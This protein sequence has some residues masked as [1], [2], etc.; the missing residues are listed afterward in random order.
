MP[1]PEHLISNGDGHSLDNLLRRTSA[2]VLASHVAELAVKRTSLNGRQANSVAVAHRDI[3]DASPLTVKRLEV[4]RQRHSL[5][6]NLVT[7][8]ANDIRIGTGIKCQRGFRI[9]A[10]PLIEW[11]V[12]VDVAWQ[13]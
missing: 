5:G 10:E 3:G 9:R 4:S 12:H 8:E 7:G 6:R 1:S 2:V 11:S 13:N